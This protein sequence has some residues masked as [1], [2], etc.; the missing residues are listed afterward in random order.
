MKLL[1]HLQRLAVIRTIDCLLRGVKVFEPSGRL[2]S[3][4]VDAIN[5][6]LKE[7]NL[8]GA[9]RSDTDRRHGGSSSSFTHQPESHPSR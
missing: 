7:V 5:V 2:K 3:C 8:T 6:L 4:L 9:A 1:L